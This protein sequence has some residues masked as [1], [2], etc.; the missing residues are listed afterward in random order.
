[1]TNEQMGENFGITDYSFIQASPAK[2][3]GPEIVSGQLVQAIS[4]IPKAVLQNYTAA[5][6]VQKNYL[7]PTADLYDS[8]KEKG[9]RNHPGDG[10][11]YGACIA[12]PAYSIA[13]SGIGS[14][15]NYGSECDDRGCRG[16]VPGVE[17]GAG[18]YCE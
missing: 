7:E 17:D 1:M 13:G 10:L 12:V 11:L 16:D 15:R 3:M 5:I 6:K 8:Y 4:D 2:G 14:N 18:E 9:I